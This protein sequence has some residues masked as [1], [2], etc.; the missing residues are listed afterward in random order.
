MG[1]GYGRMEVKGYSSFLKTVRL[2][3]EMKNMKYI[4]CSFI[5]IVLIHFQTE[6]TFLGIFLMGEKKKRLLRLQIKPD[7]R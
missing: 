2:E 4:F 1:A 3:R 7:F 5:W 6:D